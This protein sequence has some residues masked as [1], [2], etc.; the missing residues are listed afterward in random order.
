VSFTKVSFECFFN[1][2]ISTMI[3]VALWTL[4][5]FFPLVFRSFRA[6]LETLFFKG[7]LFS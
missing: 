6:S 5:P 2:A 7:F 3:L 1:E 4:F